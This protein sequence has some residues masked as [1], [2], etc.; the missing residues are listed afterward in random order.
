M[1][2]GSLITVLS[3]LLEILFCVS[4]KSANRKV[5]TSTE[6]FKPEWHRVGV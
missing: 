3:D 5:L 4:S 6:D 2:H 1:T